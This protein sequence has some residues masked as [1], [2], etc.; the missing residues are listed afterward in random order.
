[1][2]TNYPDSPDLFLEPTLPEETPLS[3]AGPGGTR[4]HT[5][6]HRDLGDAIEAIEVTASVK[7]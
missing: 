1:M 4:N 2:P 3:G 6:H 5:E 7:L